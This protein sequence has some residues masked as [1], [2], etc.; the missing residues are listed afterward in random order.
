MI[1][2]FLKVFLLLSIS[3]ATFA[4]IKISTYNIRNFNYN[5]SGD[6]GTNLPELKRIISSTQSDIVGIQEIKNE[7]EFRKFLKKHLPK[8]ALSLSKCGGGGGQKLGFI[9]K[10][11]RFKVVKTIEDRRLTEI[12]SKNPEGCGSLRPAMIVTFQDRILD[13][14][15][16]GIA[17][18]LKAGSGNR[19]YYKRWLQYEKLSKIINEQK[20]KRR[21]HIFVLGDFNTT[22]YLDKD[23]DYRN[24]TEMLDRTG[25]IES[26]EKV[27]C[28]NYWSGKATTHLPSKLDH[29]LVS[30]SFMN[31]QQ[32]R[33][34]VFGHCQK[35]R[36]EEASP[37]D[38][39][40]SYEQVSD[41]C[42]VRATFR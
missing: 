28:S 19:N 13:E 41:H 15:V 34:K 25:L 20:R 32:H 38:L 24:F 40:T 5:R 17:V 27:S 14:Q 6:E 3:T 18:H 31:L 9:F 36:C 35:R 16:T 8:Y 4:S 26:T 30:S 10:R 22:G 1:V 29:I 23:K 2:N 12:L 7:L 21:K 39:G 33:T 11:D 42:P 37:R